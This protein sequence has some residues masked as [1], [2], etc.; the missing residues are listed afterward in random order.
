MAA[1]ARVPG[2]SRDSFAAYRAIFRQHKAPRGLIC[3]CC[4]ACSSCRPV[5]HFF[6]P[7]LLV[8]LPVKVCCY[9]LIIYYNFLCVSWFLPLY[10][11][12][13]LYNSGMPILC[14]F[15]VLVC[16]LTMRERF[17][18]R[19]VAAIYARLPCIVP[20]IDTI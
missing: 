20:S 19:I 12:C 1:C 17:L 8:L 18:L 4:L 14:G 6:A 9:C 3:S 11:V 16:T 10:C 2:L 7:F 15:R 5:L 13:N